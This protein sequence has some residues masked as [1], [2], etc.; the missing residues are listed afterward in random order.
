MVSTIRV[1]ENDESDACDNSLET[2]HLM[3][4]NLVKYKFQSKDSKMF[5]TSYANIDHRK[6]VNNSFTNCSSFGS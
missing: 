2:G 4:R 1:G 6:T 3:S 5:L